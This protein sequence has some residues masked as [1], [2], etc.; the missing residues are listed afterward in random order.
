MSSSVLT[1]RTLLALSLL[2]PVGPAHGARFASELAAFAAEDARQRSPD[3]AL[4]FV[5]SSTIRLWPTLE[6]DF[7]PYPVV[8]RGFGGATLAEVLDHWALLFLPHRPAVTFLYAGE[9]DIAEGAAP[10]AVLDRFVTLRRRLASTHHADT[11]LVFINLK[12]SPARW[13]AWDR[14]Q[15]VNAAIARLPPDLAPTAVVNTE[16]FALTEAG[17]PDPLLFEADA[18]HFGPAGYRL[19]AKASF[20]ALAEVTIPHTGHR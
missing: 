9:N 5:G 18:L 14:M 16:R 10:S 15:Q 8:G 12:P 19:L 6:Q 7:A 4:L 13:D 20:A 11:P 3:A 2:A 1:R 17:R